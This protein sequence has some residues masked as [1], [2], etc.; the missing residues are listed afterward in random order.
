MWTLLGQASKASFTRLVAK[1]LKALK[2]QNF[3]SNVAYSVK[4]CCMVRPSHGTCAVCRHESGKST[5]QA[6]NTILGPILTMHTRAVSHAYMRAH[7]YA[8]AV[9]MKYTTHH[10]R[11][12][13][14]GHRRRRQHHRRHHHRHQRLLLHDIGRIGDSCCWSCSCER[15]PTSRSPMA[16][17]NKSS[18]PSPRGVAVLASIKEFR[19]IVFLVRSSSLRKQQPRLIKMTLYPHFHLHLH[20]TDGQ[21]R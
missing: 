11:G 19:H 20:Q 10:C 15:N 5:F 13:H 16:V 6:K 9:Q 18:L 4:Y 17:D 21:C 1:F 2:N 8:F 3:P 12:H 14:W 7:M